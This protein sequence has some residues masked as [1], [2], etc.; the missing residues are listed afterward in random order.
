MMCPLC[1]HQTLALPNTF[2]T[3]DLPG[4]KV[5]IQRRRCTNPACAYCK[6]SFKTEI[7]M[8]AE[9]PPEPPEAA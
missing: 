3:K 2:V 5:Y 6:A 4:S 7:I 1:K 9:R 8:D